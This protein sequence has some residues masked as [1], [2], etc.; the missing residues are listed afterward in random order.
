M[1]IELVLYYVVIFI[2]NILFI[3]LVHF[4]LC[5]YMIYGI[6]FIQVLS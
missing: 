2:F 5:F 1:Q 4:V 3:P 6:L